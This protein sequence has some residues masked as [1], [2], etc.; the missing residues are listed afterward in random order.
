MHGRLC[1]HPAKYPDF[2]HILPE[3]L[4]RLGSNTHLDGDAGRRRRLPVGEHAKVVTLV[5]Q[6]HLLGEDSY[7]LA[8]PLRLN[9]F[10]QDLLPL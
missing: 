8:S 6:L 10:C 3:V 2:V 9:R 7:E 1:T 4:R 5:G